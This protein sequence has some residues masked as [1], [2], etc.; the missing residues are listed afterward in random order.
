MA[1]ILVDLGIRTVAMIPACQAGDPGSDFLF[2][3]RN[4]DT[5]KKETKSAKLRRKVVTSCYVHFGV[6]IFL[7]NIAEK[8]CRAFES[9]PAHTQLFL[10][11]PVQKI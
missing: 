5:P 8:G 9:R 6:Q 4:S 10:I 7:A 11:A 2:E 1:K 3:E